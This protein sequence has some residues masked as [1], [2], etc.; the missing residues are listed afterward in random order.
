[1]M[2][3]KLGRFHYE[4]LENLHPLLD[5]N[6]LTLTQFFLLSLLTEESRPLPMNFIA[7]KMLQTTAAATSS[8]DILEKKGLAK[9]SPDKIDRRK[10]LVTL[11]RKGLKS[12]HSV[13]SGRADY[14]SGLLTSLSLNERAR[15]IAVEEKVYAHLT[16]PTTV[17][18]ATN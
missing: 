15:W 1:M 11:T 18:T 10:I 16:N 8:I 14:L 3:N 6:A 2:I 9:R 12:F 5:A 7:K 13:Q 4:L 17:A